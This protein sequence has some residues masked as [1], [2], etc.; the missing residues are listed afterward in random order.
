M[1]KA[2]LIKTT[3]NWGWFTGSEGQPF[4]IKAEAWQHLDRQTWYRQSREFYIF[5]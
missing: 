2:V 4:I 5:I 1:T 3:F